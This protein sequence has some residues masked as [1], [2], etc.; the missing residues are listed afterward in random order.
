M[1]MAEEIVK[2]SRKGQL[3]VPKEIREEGGFEES[4]RFIA[5]PV[6]DGV[7]FKKIDID[8]EQKYEQL[9]KQVQRRFKDADLS[10]EEL[11]DSLEHARQHITE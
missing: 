4:D 3:V 8:V 10:A 2:M 9:S 1:D 5:I 7:V 11:E 6:E